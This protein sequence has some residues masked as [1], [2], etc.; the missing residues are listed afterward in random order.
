M[1][2]AKKLKKNAEKTHFSL[3]ALIGACKLMNIFYIT[4]FADTC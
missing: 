2:A 1:K 4:K 3:Q